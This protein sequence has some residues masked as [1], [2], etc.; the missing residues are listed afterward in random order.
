MSENELALGRLEAVVVPELLPADELPERGLRAH[1]VDPQLPLEQFVVI[2][3]ELGLD[4]VDTE[5][6]DLAADVDRAVVHGVAQPAAHVPADDLPAALQHE[7][8][9]RA[10][11]AAHDD[12]AALLV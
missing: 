12:R 10:R 8:G 1:P 7:P 11:I 5:G 4:A 3:G 2:R 6:G 9:H